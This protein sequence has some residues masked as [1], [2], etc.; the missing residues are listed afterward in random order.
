MHSFMAQRFQKGGMQLFFD[1]TP[2]ESFGTPIW[3]DR[4]VMVDPTVAPGDARPGCV[5]ITAVGLLARTIGSDKLIPSAATEALP[6]DPSHTWID[7]FVPQVLPDQ[8][9]TS[10]QLT[11]SGFKLNETVSIRLTSP[12]LPPIDAGTVSTFADGSFQAV[13]SAPVGVYQMT[14]T[15]SLGDGF[16]GSLDLTAS[17]VDPANQRSQQC[18]TVGLP[19]GN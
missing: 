16:T 2:N 15:G 13:V 1:S 14:A 19:V 11:G 10:A 3:N 5:V 4:P 18:G 12:S 6:L 9:T 8:R 17:T 7:A